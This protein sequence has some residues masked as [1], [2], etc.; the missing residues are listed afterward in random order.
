MPPAAVGA[1]FVAMGATAATGAAVAAVATTVYV[2]AA[3]GALTGAVTAI[4][5]GG[6]VLDGALKGA[7]VA[8]AT[9]GI[10]K[11]F[12]LAA[13]GPAMADAGIS[14]TAATGG[15]VGGADIAGLKMAEAG[16]SQ[17]PTVGESVAP[18]LASNAVQPTSGEGTGFLSGTAN[19]INKN[20]MPA[21][22]I[23]QTVGG[24]AKGMQDSRTAQKQIDAAMERDR[25]YID[26]KKV[27]GLSGLDLKIALPSIGEFAEKPKWQ[28]PKGGLLQS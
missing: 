20:P 25:L 21:T 7:L 6:D 19:W 22:M 8:G 9:G 17:V 15:Q 12:G 2:S 27:R 24:A 23:A 14:N 16:L 26:S 4:V 11:G 13:N 1:T 28:P 3:I 10:M 5:T 18:N